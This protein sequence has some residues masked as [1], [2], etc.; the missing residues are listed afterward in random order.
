MNSNPGVPYVRPILV[1]EYKYSYMKSLVFIAF[2]GDGSN[3]AGDPYLSCFPDM[4]SIFS[5][6]PVVL[7]HLIGRYFNASNAIDNHNSMWQSDLLL[8]K[9]W[10]THSGY[11]RLATTV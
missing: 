4:Y 5:V 6:F 8:D 9:Y 2:D 1:I 3:E 10:V 11:F 7:P